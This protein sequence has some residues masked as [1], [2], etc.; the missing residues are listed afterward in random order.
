VAC[1][2][3]DL[4]GP[5]ISTRHFNIASVVRNSVGNYTVTLDQ[6]VST[7]SVIQCTPDSGGANVGDIVVTWLTTTTIEVLTYNRTTNAL[8]DDGIIHF[9]IVGSPNTLPT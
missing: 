5:T 4:S 9:A 7:D 8:I 6:P 1:A 2:K 3:F